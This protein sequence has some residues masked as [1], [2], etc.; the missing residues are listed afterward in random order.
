MFSVSAKRVY[1]GRQTNVEGLNINGAVIRWLTHDGLMTDVDL[2][3]LIDRQVKVTPD[4]VN[5]LSPEIVSVRQI[6]R[7]GRI[8]Q[9]SWP[10]VK[11]VGRRQ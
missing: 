7:P 2:Q 10:Q 8:L 3:V 6:R 11:D 9:H 4:T 5:Y 1:E